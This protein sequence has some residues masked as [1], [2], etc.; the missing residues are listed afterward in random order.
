MTDNI[1]FRPITPT[2]MEFLYQVYAST[3]EVELEVVPWTTQEKE[4][5][6]R[7]QFNAQ[8]VFYQEQFTQAE[9]KIILQNER[10]IGRLY[11]NYQPDEIRI[12]DIALLF[13]YRRKGTGTSLLHDILAQAQMKAVP[14][15]IHVE[16][17]NP[18]LNL[19]TRLGFRQI[20]IHGVYFLME[21]IPEQK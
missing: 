11:I 18:A 17:N 1:T 16:H 13:R 21:W 7:M 14:V 10:P 6:L 2:D 15:R 19:Y 5:F 4:N 12:I 3:R 8:H 20:D 9:F